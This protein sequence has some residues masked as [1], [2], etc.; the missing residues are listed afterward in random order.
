MHASPLR[1]QLGG[2]VPPKIATPRLVVRVPSFRPVFF[3]ALPCPSAFPLPCPPTFPSSSLPVMILTARCSIS[4]GNIYWQYPHKSLVSAQVLHRYSPASQKSRLL[5]RHPHPASRLLLQA[6]QGPRPRPL[7]RPQ[8]PLLQRRERER[9]PRARAHRRH[10]FDWV[11]AGL[12]AC[13]VLVF[14]SRR[15]C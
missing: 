1:R 9:C 14:T 7:R 10:L 8:R 13:V 5:R 11:Y 12:S 15:L 4:T 3:R 6:P 2:L